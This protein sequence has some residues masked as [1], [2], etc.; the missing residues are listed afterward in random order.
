MEPMK[1]HPRL[2][3]LVVEDLEFWNSGWYGARVRGLGYEGVNVADIN[4]MPI[5]W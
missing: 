2:M 3:A 5:G 4:R 1:M